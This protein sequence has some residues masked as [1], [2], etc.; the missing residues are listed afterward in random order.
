MGAGRRIPLGLLC[1]RGQSAG[2]VWE[3]RARMGV[4]EGMCGRTAR[5]SEVLPEKERKR[6]ASFYE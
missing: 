1:R 5:S 4:E 3:V 6:M 2:F